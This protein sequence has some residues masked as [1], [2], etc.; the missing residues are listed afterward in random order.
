M[1]IGIFD[2]YLDSLGGGERYAL[3]VAEHLSKDH[4]IEIF[5]DGRDLKSEIKTRL[6]LNLD[7]TKFVSNVFT[8]EKSL[9]EKLVKTSSYDLIFYLSDGSIPTSAAKSNILHFQ[10]PFSHIKA[11]TVFNRLK[12]SR[13]NWVICNSYFTK[14]FIDKTYGVKSVVIYPPVDVLSFSPRRKRNLILSV[15]RFTGSLENKKLEVMIEVFKSLVDRGLTAWDFHL[16][17]GMLEN[18]KEYFEKLKSQ[19]SGYPIRLLPNTSFS[20]LK[21]YYSEAK[22]YWHAKGYGENEEK[23]PERFEHFGISCVEAMAAGGVPV[24]FNGGGLREIIKEGCGFLWSTK[25]ELQGFTGELI[26]NKDKFLRLSIEARRRAYDFSKE[27]F[28]R[29][30]DEIIFG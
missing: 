2:P 12:L 6:S 1:K 30:F 20:E 13:F 5:W 25:K 17:G 4:Q 26:R 21:K 10:T 3:T 22:I 15:G 19:V 29:R 23:S 24:V 16:I 27:N 18:D 14:K 11:K 28:L 7:K 9:L 8:R